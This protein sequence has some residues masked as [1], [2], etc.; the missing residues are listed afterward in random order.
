MFYRQN[1]T[2]GFTLAEVLITLGIIGIISAITIPELIANHKNKELE[3]RFKKSYSLLAQTLQKVVLDDYGGTYEPANSI[4]IV[5][6][7]QKYY[8][9][10]S[11]CVNGKECNSSI[12]PVKDYS[13]TNPIN[14][15]HETYKT[16]SGNQGGDSKF[17]DGIIAAVDGSFI[18]VDEAQEGELTYGIY[19]IAID[20]NGWKNKPNRFGH[21]FFVFQLGKNGKLLPMG[22]DGTYYEEDEY[23][24]V[25]SNS[26][27]NGYGCTSKALSD[28]NYFKNLPK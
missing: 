10:S 28:R 26:K 9:K 13:G 20:T 1:I 11:T 7:I 27:V 2:M 17:N 3:T 6:S 22:A 8:N 25:K 12:F 5:N 18:Y 23:C 14:F 15:L 16:F 24:S 4:S 21:D 19:F